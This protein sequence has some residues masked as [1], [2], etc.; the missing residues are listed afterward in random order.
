M[1][2]KKKIKKFRKTVKVYHARAQI[3]EIMKYLFGVSKQTL[4][5]ML[6]SLFKQNF[7]IDNAEIIQTN[8]EFIDENFDITRG[9]LFFL[10]A[11]KSKRYNLHIELQTRADGHIVIRILEYDNEPLDKIIKYSELAE[12]KIRGL[13]EKLSKEII[14]NMPIEEK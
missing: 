5:N 13:A 1:M 14:I 12:E 6:N 4:L 9:D 8:S 7:S 10:V 11:D 2:K 3:D